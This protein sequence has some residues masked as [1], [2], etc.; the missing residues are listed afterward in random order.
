LGTRFGFGVA[1]DVPDVA[2]PDANLSVVEDGPATPPEVSDV[3]TIEDVACV[4]EPVLLLFAAE[5]EFVPLSL[6]ATA[7]RA[8]EMRTERYIFPSWYQR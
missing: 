1:G 7:A 2:E 5:A 3:V 8:I 4:V 6:Q